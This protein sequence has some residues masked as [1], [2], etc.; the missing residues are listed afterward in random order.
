MVVTNDDV[1]KH[2]PH[3]EGILKIC[4]KLGKPLGHSDVRRFS[5]GEVF[6]E[7]GENVRGR[8]ADE[9]CGRQSKQMA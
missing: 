7:V 1:Q 2:K 5:D 4:E 3:P 9:Q 8:D 6:V